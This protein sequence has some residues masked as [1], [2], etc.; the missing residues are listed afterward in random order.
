MAVDPPL[1]VSCVA[2]ALH[3]VKD[4]RLETAELARQPSVTYR[5]RI[6]R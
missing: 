6:M 4:H 2:R 3:G 5:S 1:I